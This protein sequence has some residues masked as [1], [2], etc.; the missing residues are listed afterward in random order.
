MA[1]MQAPPAQQL[2]H[3]EDNDARSDGSNDSSHEEGNNHVA[4]TEQHVTSS[5]PLE[6]EWTFWYDKRP[7]QGKRLKGEQESYESNLRPIGTIGSVSYAIVY[8]YLR[9][10]TYSFLLFMHR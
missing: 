9:V 8:F 4:G 1:E 7:A 5:H 10:S 6:Y 2:Q 3:E